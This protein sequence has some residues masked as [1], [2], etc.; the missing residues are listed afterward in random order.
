MVEKA[1]LP[2]KIEPVPVNSPL[3]SDEIIV[4]EYTTGIDSQVSGP[5]PAPTPDPDIVQDQGVSGGPLPSDTPP[6][7][8]PPGDAPKGD[9]H[10]DPDVEKLQDTTREFTF[11]GDLSQPPGGAPADDK[12]KSPTDASISEEGTDALVVPEVSAKAFAELAGNIVGI[13]VPKWGYEYVKID[14][15]NIRTHVHKGNLAPDFFNIFEDVNEKVK[16]ELKFDPEEIK[17]FKKATK[18]YV[19]YKGVE[20]ANPETTFFIS[21]GALSLS[22][23]QKLIGLKKELNLMVLDG[24]KVTNPSLFKDF[25]DESTAREHVDN[26]K[27]EKK[28]KKT[29]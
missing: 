19:E 18:D 8:T 3:L 4:R 23:G 25:K 20:W 6:S 26:G 14:M 5:D 15:K 12:V 11:S 7:D 24:L 27:A 10:L 9:L 29:D 1:N 22:F 21:A 17:M 16:E 2:A 28:D 13:Y